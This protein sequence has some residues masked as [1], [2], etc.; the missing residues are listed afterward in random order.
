MLSQQRQLSSLLSTVRK[1]QRTISPTI[2]AAPSALRDPE[3]EFI[4]YSG[5]LQHTEYGLSSTAWQNPLNPE[6]AHGREPIGNLNNS[7]NSNLVEN[8]NI[9]MA[10]LENLMQAKAQSGSLGVDING[11]EGGFSMDNMDFQC[12]T[13]K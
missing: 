2:I 1:R 12:P 4:Q 9:Y 13:R 6:D 3:I 7:S 10:N 5:P 11:Y 8:L